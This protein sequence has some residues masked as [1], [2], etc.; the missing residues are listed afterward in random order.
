MNYT[1][2]QLKNMNEE[3]LLA[4]KDAC[5]DI[6]PKIDLNTYNAYDKQL[7]KMNLVRDK[8]HIFASLYDSNDIYRKSNLLLR[9]C[10]EIEKRKEV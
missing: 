4:L 5:E 1:N 3:L 2:K 10:T 7:D 9:V 8:K 6:Q